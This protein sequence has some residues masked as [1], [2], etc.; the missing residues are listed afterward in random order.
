M[1]I[2]N[3]FLYNVLCRFGSVY[4]LDICNDSDKFLD[5]I[6]MFNDNWVQYNSRK[7]VNRYGLSITSLDGNLSGIPDLDSLREYSIENNIL[8]TETDIVTKTPVYPMASRWL[9]K[10]S[11]HICRTHL[12]RLGP[13]GFFP[14]HRDN[15]IIGIDTFRL[16]VPLKNCN[17]PAMFFILNKETLN[18]EKGRMYFIDTCLEHVVFNAHFEDSIFMVVNLKINREC[19]DLVLSSKEIT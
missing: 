14:M 19:V 10:F 16:L 17:P 6:S 8:V 9:D 4:A 18:F 7:N 3:V 2:D 1:N 5:D 15:N 13:G 12:I 11:D